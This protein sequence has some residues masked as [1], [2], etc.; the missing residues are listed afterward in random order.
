MKTLLQAPFNS[1]NANLHLGLYTNI[2]W[3]YLRHLPCQLLCAQ[4]YV[5]L[6]SRKHRNTGK[7]NTIC[8]PDRKAMY[9]LDVMA[10]L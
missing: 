2:F 10:F 9:V 4:L 5:G 6:S 8:L 1:V 3:P 7:S